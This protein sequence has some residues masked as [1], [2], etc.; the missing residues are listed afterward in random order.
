M[1]GGITLNNKTKEA[2]FNYKGD[3]LFLTVTM[4]LM[5]L[6][7]S[8]IAILNIK[9][10]SMY[11]TYQDGNILIMKVEKNVDKNNIIIFDSPKSWDSEERKFIKRAIATE[12]DSLEIINS[13]LKVNGVSFKETEDIVCENPAILDELILKE[14]EVFVMGDNVGYSND[15]FA[16]LCNGNK[17]FLIKDNKDI[18]SGSELM[19]IERGLF[20]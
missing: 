10:N 18:I 6:V 4:V 5:F 2:A 9:G 8:H 15:S 12:G 13:S 19:L 17:D 7:S 16:Q 14:N 3:I 1:L 11:P 20:N